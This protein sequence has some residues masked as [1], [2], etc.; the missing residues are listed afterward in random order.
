M[1]CNARKINNNVELLCRTLLDPHI[2]SRTHR[3]DS[4]RLSRKN[5]TLIEEHLAYS[6]LKKRG[7]C[8]NLSETRKARKENCMRRTAS[9]GRQMQKPRRQRHVTHSRPEI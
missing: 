9:L 1:G 7:I 5:E 8:T 3:Q 6:M 4:L 2:E